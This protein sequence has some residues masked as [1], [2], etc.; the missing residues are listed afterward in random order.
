MEGRNEEEFVCQKD[1]WAKDGIVL[2]LS[3]EARDSRDSAAPNKPLIGPILIRSPDSNLKPNRVTLDPSAPRLTHKYSFSWAPTH[4]TLRITKLLDEKR[5]AH[6]IVPQFPFAPLTHIGNDRGSSCAEHDDETP[7][8][9][10]GTADACPQGDLTPSPAGEDIGSLSKLPL[11]L[12]KE[13]AISALHCEPLVMVAPPESTEEVSGPTSEPSLWVKQRHWGFCKLVGFP[14]ESHEQECLSLLQRIEADRFVYKEKVGSRRPTASVKKGTCELRRGLNNPKKRESIKYWLRS[15]KC[16]VVCLQETKLAGDE[17]FVDRIEA[18]WSSYS[19]CGPPSLVLAC[20][21]KALKEDLKKW[22]YHVFGN[23]S[24]KQQQLFCELEVL[25]CKEQ[26]GGLSSSELEHR[27]ALLLDLDKLAHCEETSWRQKSRVLWLKEGDNNTKFFHKIANSNRRRNF[28]EKLE[29]GDTVFSSDSDIRDQAV[30]FY[31]SLYME[32][33]PW[34]PFVDDLPFSVIGDVDRNLLVSRFEK[35][36]ILQVGTFTYSLNATFVTL[37]SKKQNAINIWDFR[38]VSLIGSVYK[39]L[40]NRLRWVLDGV[41]SESQNAFVGGRQTLDSILIANECLDSRIKCRT[42][43]VVCKLDIEKAYDQV[44]WD[45]LLYLMDRM[46]FGRKWISWIRTCISTV[47]FSIMVNGSPFGFFGSRGICQGDPLSPLLF[48][49]IMEVLSRMLRRME[50][51]LHL[52]MVLSCFEVVTG[53]GVN[54]G[55]SEL[56]PVGE[57]LNLSHLAD[58]LCCRIG[59][60]PMSYL[61]LPL[62]ASFKAFSI[63]NPILEKVERRLAGWKK[64]YLSKGGRLTLLK[65]TLSSLLTY[66]LSLFTIPKHVAARIEKLQRNFLWGGPYWGNGCGSLVG[67]KLTFGGVLL[68]RN[69]AWIVQV[70]LVADWVH[71]F[72]SGMILGVGMLLSRPCFLFFLLALPLVEEVLAFI[73][74]IHSKIPVDLAPDSISW[75][76][77]QNGEFDVK[78]FYHALDVK[79]DIKF[80]WRA[81]W[82]VKAPRPREPFKS[83]FF[84]WSAAWGKDSFL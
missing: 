9:L 66:Y 5:Q 47:R 3:L 84:L 25:N 6:W 49:L 51:V 75:K 20:K 55:K 40:A 63:W 60:L 4:K 12:V 77:R 68:W 10:N 72:G 82:R 48:L 80:P 8:E 38:P 11:A 36:E 78:S 24:V 31:E 67:K 30:Q 19:F 26:Q 33:E 79:V 37:I 57:V 42:P 27:G 81:I 7:M 83:C 46:G 29:V 76:L 64:L 65:S 34:R 2:Q 74:F 16:D 22:N 35:E 61:G 71:G 41:V 15:W 1:T 21:L 17:G 58:I 14:I 52:R 59:S 32:K 44:N 69:M 50:E 45:C 43:G 73:N 70:E 53:L 54:M 13:H 23:V 39:I 28:M 56:V 18:W 62:G